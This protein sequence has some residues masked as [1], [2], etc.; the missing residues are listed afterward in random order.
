LAQC[1]AALS[2]FGFD[3]DA[4]RNGA[5]VLMRLAQATLQARLPE[6][7][8]LIDLPPQ[9]KRHE[10]E[11][12][13]SLRRA[14]GEDV[15]A[16]LHRFGYCLQR[17]RL[18]PPPG[19][20]GLL[21]GK[22]DLLYRHGEKLFLLDYKSNRLPDY[23]EDGLR[24]AIRAQE[25]DLQY[26]LYTVAVHRWLRRRMPGYR[27]ERHFGGVRYLFSRG[28]DPSHPDNGIFRDRPDAGLIMAL[29]ACF[30]AEAV[31]DA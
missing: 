9:D 26:L 6:G 19:L 2:A 15:L 12:H 20:N 18:G 28:I 4:A 11:F 27:Y 23:G 21:T 1:R 3:A 13:L 29:D 22:I 5:A 14:G 30:D 8:A 25:Y 31:T 16:L 10:M 24:Q 7:A 17:T